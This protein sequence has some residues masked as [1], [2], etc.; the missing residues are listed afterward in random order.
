M[1]YSHNRVSHG[2]KYE[3]EIIPYNAMQGVPGD[4]RYKNKMESLKH[5]MSES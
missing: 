2:Y 5:L 3:R 1:V 4:I